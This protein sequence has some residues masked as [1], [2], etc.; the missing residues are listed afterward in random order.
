MMRLLHVLAVATIVLPI[1]VFAAGGAIAWQDIRQ[2]AWDKSARTVDLAYESTSRLFDTNLLVLDQAQQLTAGLDDAAITAH[3]SELHQRLAAMLP[4]M[5]HV[6]DVFVVGRDGRVIVDSLTDPAPGGLDLNDCDYVRYF[7]QGG[8]GLFV[9]QPNLRQPDG[10]RY[11][12]LAIR[13]DSADGR[14]NG[15]IAASVS[16]EFFETLFARSEAAYTDVPGRTISL[17]RASDGLLLVRSPPGDA[18]AEAP[19]RL[20]AQFHQAAG[21]R[22]AVRSPLDD[23]THLLAWRRLA[24]VGI[25]IM[26]SI[27]RGAVL[28]DWIAAMVPQLCFG[29]PATIALFILTRLTIRRARQAEAAAAEAETERHRRQ[30]AD[31]AEWQRQKMEALGKLTGGLAHDFNNLLAVILGSAELARTRP[32]EKIGRL[33]DNILHAGQRAATLTRQLLTFARRQPLVPRVVD[34]HAGLPHLLEVL[35]P[36]LGSRVVIDMLVAEDVWLVEVDP[37]E[38]ESALLNVAANARDAMPNGG[39]FVVEVVNRILAPGEIAGAPH[40][41]GAYIAVSLQDSGTGMPV[42]VASRAFEPFFTTKEIGRG[43]G[44]GL[45][46]VYGFARQ[47]GGAATLESTPGQGT[48]VT[49]FLPRSQ[50]PLGQGGVPAE[51]SVGGGEGVSRR[52]LLVEDEGPVAAL[53]TDMLETLGYE[54]VAVEGPRAALDRLAEPKRAVHL[55]LSD[56]TM[57]GGMTGLDLV[58]LTRDRMPALPVLLMSGN[59]DVLAVQRDGVPLLRKPF[60]LEQLAAAVRAALGE[61]PRIVVDNTRVA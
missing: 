56:E 13:R 18:P 12:A 37:P 29:L 52:I 16:P 20:L 51:A 14:F 10:N 33:L 5:P 22:L 40:L 2:D 54:V 26:T 34:L 21:G 50:K 30:Q 15:V 4:F 43:T 17:R 48:T 44:L 53:V 35:R 46:Q 8:T 24:E 42:D 11:F 47:A 57:P 28:R 41:A 61:F 7:M 39:T 1:A 31:D 23:Q 27:T 19:D 58:R 45:S 36:A 25:V 55:L 6:R 9:S 49:L 32:P 3:Q 60:S 59:A 38:W